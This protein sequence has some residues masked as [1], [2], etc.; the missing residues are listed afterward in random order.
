M[1]NSK[2]SNLA[3]QIETYRMIDV[4]LMIDKWRAENERERKYGHD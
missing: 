4:P 3:D 1:T 2:E